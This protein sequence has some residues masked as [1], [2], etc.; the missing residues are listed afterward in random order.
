MEGCPIQVA[1]LMLANKEHVW[2]RSQALFL[3]RY[4]LESRKARSLSV[5]GEGTDT[6]RVKWLVLYYVYRAPPLGRWTSMSGFDGPGHA[7]P[8]TAKR[9]NCIHYAGTFKGNG[10]LCQNYKND[11]LWTKQVRMSGNLIL[12]SPPI[13]QNKNI[14]SSLSIL[15]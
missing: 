1:F 7:Q 10:P 13:A 11:Y 9:R 5:A 14:A 15:G 12:F 4:P 2:V 3:V 6:N 8:K